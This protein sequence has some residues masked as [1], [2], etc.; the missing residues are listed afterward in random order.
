[1][2]TAR[3][4]LKDQL[5]TRE[6]VELIAGEIKHVDSAFKADEF[7]TMVVARFPELELKARIA[8]ITTCLERHLPRNFRKAASALVRSLPAPADPALSDGD[9]GDFIYAPYAEYVAQRGCTAEDL[10]F[11]LAMLRA[12]TTRFSAE[13]AIR[14]FL[15]AFPDHVLTTLLAWTGDQH[16]HV[17]R[18][19]SE[20]TR[21]RLP[22]AR[23]LTLPYDVGIPILDRL[24]AD[25][26]RYVTRSVANHVNDVSKKNPELAL[27]TLER[28][29]NSGLQQ[30]REM[31]Y[32]IR[33]GARTLRRADHPRARDLVSS[34]LT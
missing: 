2:T 17:R 16:Y 3:L 34:P 27:D 9:F 15:D 21:P 28:W 5:F 12:I 22:W 31:H 24:F 4:P 25:P 1:M 29:R 20:G 18:L 14:P 30:P 19:C 8:W 26:T 7:V 32:V 13:F 6:K 10:E 23:N 11:S 33:H